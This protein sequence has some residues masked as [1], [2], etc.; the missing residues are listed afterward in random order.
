MK[1]IFAVLLAACIAVCSY[2]PSVFAKKEYTVPTEKPNSAGFV[3][4]E[5]AVACFITAIGIDKFRTDDDILD[6]FSDKNKISFSYMDEM[7]AAVFSGLIS[8]YEDGTLRPQM[9]ITRIEALVILNRALS[10]IELGDWYDVEFSDVPQWASRQIKRLAAAGIVKGYGDGCLG[11][12][13]LLTIEQVNTLCERI[14]RYMGPSGDFYS[15]INAD[16]LEKTSLSDGSVTT[17]DLSRIESELNTKV[18]DIIFY[19][20]RRYFNDGA[21]YGENTDEYRIITAY[22]AAANM[23]HRDKIGFEPI[24]ELLDMI[25]KIGNKEQLSDAIITL[26]KSGFTTVLP[27]AADVSVFDSSQYTLSV[28]GFYT[29]VSAQLLKGDDSEKYL[30]YYREYISELLK[31][32]GDENPDNTSAYAAELCK[33]IAL[34]KDAAADRASLAQTVEEWSPERL[35]K[36]YSGLNVKKIL[37]ELGRADKNIVVYDPKATAAAGAISTEQNIDKIKAYL[38]AALLDSSAAYLTSDAFYAYRNYKNK[39]FGV[40]DN[41]IPADYAVGITRELMGWELS[42]LYID[43]YFPE[44]SKDNI[45]KLTQDIIAQYEKIIGSSGRLTPQ[46]RAA[47]I[48]KMK[49]ISV[50]AAFP[51]DFGEYINRD[52]K[53]RPTSD[54]GSLMEYKTTKANSAAENFKK[55]ITDNASAKRGGWTIYPYT[56][57][58]MYDPVSNSITI[59]AG[60]LQAPLYEASA[61]YEEN[62]GGIGFVIA[63]EISHAFDSVGAYFDES[64]NINKWWTEQDYNSFGELCQKII[65]EYNRINIDGE[66]ID[67]ALTLNENIADIAAMSCIIELAK[68]KKCDMPRMFSAYAKTWRTKSTSEYQKYLIKTDSHSPSKIRVNR[69]LSNFDDFAECYEITEGDG[70]FIPPDRRINIWK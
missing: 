69:V 6:K 61:T 15:Y 37:T 36:T 39:V 45:K 7:S 53:M 64:G 28:S 50:N 58:A 52:Y 47:A 65:D 49:S 54:G 43:M 40:S 4:R 5:Q 41:S 14:T 60:I 13:D 33:A 12:G 27:L 29:G 2:A 17:S 21:E 20:Y 22:S 68:D 24:R 1:R 62:L 35:E 32:S 57:N 55:L 70:M 25:D 31:L 16:W 63:H 51:D 46:T 23:G 10:R 59:P 38:K 34:E 8:G 11:S 30:G 67:G 56:A 26:E 44:T 3:T 48:K 66:N 19:L 18:G 42:N 9:Q